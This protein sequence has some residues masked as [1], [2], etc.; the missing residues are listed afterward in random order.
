MK[1]HSVFHAS[2]LSPYHETEPHGP[3]Y[4]D[5]PPEIVD[6]YEKYKPEAILTHK[7]WY[8]STA[9]LIQ[10]KNRFIAENSWESEWHLKNTQELL[11]EYK[12]R[13]TIGKR[14][15]PTQSSSTQSTWTQLTSA[16]N[17]LIMPKSL[18]SPLT[19]L[20]LTD[21]GKKE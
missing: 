12:D 3:N 19:L 9:Y 16:L 20:K 18:L 6:D 7:P 8:G 5:T 10:W 17:S 14:N 2:L 1:I 15:Q 4:F 21:L 11:H 13:H